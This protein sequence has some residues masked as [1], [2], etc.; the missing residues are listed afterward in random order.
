MCWSTV[1][2]QHYANVLLYVGQPWETNTKPIHLNV[3][4][5][6]ETNAMPIH[7]NVGQ[8][9][10]TNTMPTH[11]NVGQQWYTNAMPIYLDVGQQLETSG[12]PIHL[13]VGQ[14]WETNTVPTFTYMLVNSGKPTLCQSFIYWSTVGHQQYANHGKCQ[15][16]ST[17]LQ[18]WANI[19]IWHKTN[20]DVRQ[21]C[22]PKNN[23]GPRSSCL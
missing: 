13:Y 5:Q 2:N 19:K 20:G 8:S 1:G 21:P 9:W 6:W 7:L 11:L 23:V 12:M 4:Q 17:Q 10:E 18:H 22:Q 14:L 3:G 16:K 15:P